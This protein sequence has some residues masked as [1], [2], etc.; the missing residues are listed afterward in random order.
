M[1]VDEVTIDIFGGR[2]GDGRAHFDGSKSKEGIDGGNGGDGGSVFVIGVSDLGALNQFRF[3]KSF[4][5]EDGGR[6][7][8]KKMHGKNGEDMILKVP[9]GTI[10]HNLDTNKKKEVL[11]VGDTFK[12]ASGGKGGRGNVEFKSSRNTSPQEF[13]IG[14]EGEHFKIFL[15]LQLIAQVGFIGLPNAGKSS[16]LNE[17]TAASAKVANYR[18]TTLEPN[19]GVLDGLILADIPGL[20]DGASLG[21]G[22]GIKFLKHIKRTKTIIHFIS[23]ESEDL[24]EDY[25]IIQ[26]ELKKYDPL[27]ADREKCIFLT[28]HDLCSKKKIEEKI[29]IL[30]KVSKNIIPVSVYDS[31][32]IDV[33]KAMLFK[34]TGFNNS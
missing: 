16:M 18:F 3:K 26:S 4:K 19:L 2:G 8:V 29:K 15:E 21:K 1:L 9:I 13:E 7:G 32:S 12:I 6:G 17:L 23:I 24:I 11:N 10:I 25:N 33:V 22:L 31:D 20:I 27:L 30:K 5:T 28:K 14:K 34:L